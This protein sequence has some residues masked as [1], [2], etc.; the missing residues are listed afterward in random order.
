[1]AVEGMARSLPLWMGNEEL[2]KQGDMSEAKLKNLISSLLPVTY[3]LGRSIRGDTA[4]TPPPDVIRVG[5][6]QTLWSPESPV[7]SFPLMSALPIFNL[8]NA[9]LKL[10]RYAWQNRAEGNAYTANV[11]SINYLVYVFV[12]HISH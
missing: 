10:L 4:S 6:L 12:I 1:M 5:A 9:S 2:S 11:N 7:T 8:S 3:D